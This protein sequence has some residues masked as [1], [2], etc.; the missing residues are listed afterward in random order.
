M[1]CHAIL[2][3]DEAA[4]RLV[5]D[6]YARCVDT[7]DAICQMNLFTVHSQFLVYMDGKTAELPQ[8]FSGRRPLSRYL[9]I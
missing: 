1:T 3:A 7:R 8:V 5:I 9:T 2:S 6:A 4:D